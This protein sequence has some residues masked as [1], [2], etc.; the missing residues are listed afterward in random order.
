MFDASHELRT[1]I[2]AALT[3]AQVTLQTQTRSEQ[4]YRDALR[5]VEE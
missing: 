2:A 1:P 5:I 3:T 4:E